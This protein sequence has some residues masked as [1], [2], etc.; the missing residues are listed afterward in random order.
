MANPLPPPLP[1]PSR[2]KRGR[3][4][5]IAAAVFSILI[6]LLIVLWRNSNAKARQALDA[7]DSAMAAEVEQYISTTLSNKGADDPLIKRFG[8]FQRFEGTGFKRS[9][10]WMDIPEDVGFS[11]TAVFAR[12]KVP[13]SISIHTTG[14]LNM[15]L[16][17]YPSDQWL[18]DN[19]RAIEVSSDPAWFAEHPDSDPFA[20]QGPMQVILPNNT[21]TSRST[22]MGNV[23]HPNF[24]KR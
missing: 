21:G 23:T 3:L 1:S 19:P 13:I 9:S 10:G 5:N 15:N 4:P 22:I 14:P 12:G 6:C 24:R 2:K 16:F 7:I 11:R 20:T 18:A 17:V 8:A